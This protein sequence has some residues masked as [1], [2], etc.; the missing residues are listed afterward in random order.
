MNVINLP[1]DHFAGQ[2]VLGHDIIIQ[3]FSVR[4]G[5]LRG[6]GVLRRN[7]VSLVI[8]G[9]K[10][11]HF[12]QRTVEAHDGGFHFLSSGNC[13]ATIDLSRQAEFR[14]ILVYFTD[15]A[16]MDFCV[17]NEGLIRRRSQGYKITAE[18]YISLEK[19][20][21]IRHYIRSLQL[22]LGNGGP[23]SQEMK[24]L[25]FEE[26]MLYLLER[27]PQALLSFHASVNRPPHQ[28]EIRR[29]VETNITNNLTVNELAF[30]CNLSPSSFKRNFASIYQTS[31]INWFLEQRMKMAAG[32]L[33]QNKEKP[34]EIYHKLGYE[35][36]SGFSKSFRK[37]YG[38]SPS[39]FQAMDVREQVLNGQA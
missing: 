27:R 17:R 7:A 33:R 38:M 10:T 39:E 25:K 24:L 3:E 9:H 29:V 19:D 28:L 20:E 14:S 21:F 11:M 6:P 12:S 4:Q 2:E 32:L 5:S 22:L 36:H 15:R 30:L 31:P 23:I 35:N 16:L 13:I 1:D 8:Q 34:G 18:P 26:L 37:F